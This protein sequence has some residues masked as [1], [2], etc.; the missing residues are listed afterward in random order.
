MHVV[1]LISGWGCR[2]CRRKELCTSGK[3]SSPEWDPRTPSPF[4]SVLSEL[5][6][7]LC[8]SAEAALVEVDMGLTFSLKSVIITVRSPTVTSK[9]WA[10]LLSMFFNLGLAKEQKK[11]RPKVWQLQTDHFLLWKIILVLCFVVKLSD[12][13]QT[14]G[15]FFPQLI[16]VARLQ[17]LWCG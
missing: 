15:H 7:W 3:K 5:E 13:D 16:A 14:F 1:V 9:C 10:L 17:W 8:W 4:Y 12:V 11:N 2:Q 6:L